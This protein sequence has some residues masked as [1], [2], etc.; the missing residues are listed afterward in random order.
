MKERDLKAGDLLRTQGGNTALVL[1][2]REC[3]RIGGAGKEAV[4][5]FDDGRVGLI[6]DY[7]C[8]GMWEVVKP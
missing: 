6:P 8:H 2:V 4:A 5:L 3:I 1:S 7:Q